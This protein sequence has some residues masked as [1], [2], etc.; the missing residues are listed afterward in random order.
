VF[1]SHLSSF[2]V[3]ILC[4]FGLAKLLVDELVVVAPVPELCGVS[5]VLQGNVCTHGVASFDGESAYGAPFTT[6]RTNREDV[7]VVSSA[8]DRI[9][10]E[11]EVLLHGVL[12]RHV[13][14]AEIA[15]PEPSIPLLTPIDSELVDLESRRCALQH[16]V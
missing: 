2:L 4:S 1:F 12:A 6:S 7:L 13:L 11:L 9:D 8:L 14:G 5:F 16:E 10:A 3:H 15:L